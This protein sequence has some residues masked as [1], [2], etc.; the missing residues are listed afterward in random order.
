MTKAAESGEQCRLFVDAHSKNDDLWNKHHPREEAIAKL[1]TISGIH[2]T[3]LNYQSET[4]K[5]HYTSHKGKEL[6]DFRI[7]AFSA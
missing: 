3:D 7:F 5:G 6:Q 2:G 4:W 1:L